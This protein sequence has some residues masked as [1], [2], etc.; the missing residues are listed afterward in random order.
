[1]LSQTEQ[2]DIAGQAKKIMDDFIKELEKL[3]E[4]KEFG[5]EREHFSRKPKKE[6]YSEKNQNFR[7]SMLDN[8]PKIKD[9]CILAE[10]KSW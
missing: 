6:N 7:E 8:S 4:L 2:E 1:M 5:V 10:K 9:G 3:P